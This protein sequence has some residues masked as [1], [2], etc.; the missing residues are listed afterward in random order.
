MD[1]LK[2]YFLTDASKVREYDNENN[3]FYVSSVT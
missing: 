3:Y 1:F 2:Y